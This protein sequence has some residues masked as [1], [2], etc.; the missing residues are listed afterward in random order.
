ME[1]IREAPRMGGFVPLTEFQSV[2]PETFSQPVLHY[3]SD[4][5]KVIVLE[6]ELQH[7]PAIAELITKASQPVH[8][9]EAESENTNG[10]QAAQKT[11]EDIDVWVTSEKLFL[12]SK[13][14]EIG[15]TISYPTIS[16][17]ATQSYPAPSPD[18]PASQALYMQLIPSLPDSPAEDDDPPDTVSLT[19]IPTAAAPP[20]STAPTAN[21]DDAITSENEPQLTPVQALYKALSDCSDLHP[22]PAQDEDMEE[23]G[24]SRL[25]PAGLAIPGTTD[26]SMPP[27]MPGSGGWITAEN[28]HEFVDEEGNWIGGD[29][30]EQEDAQ[31]LG[32][33]A[34]T[35]RSRPDGDAQDGQDEETKWQRTS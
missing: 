14:H 1:V 33:G 15:L 12:Y 23:S 31:N 11:V 13:S 35:V 18:E 19:I 29:D 30:E 17:H 34:G 6:D 9:N 28:M 5:C 4:R 7:A 16:I 26:G 8:S 2:T 3:Y 22:D 20:P 10:A 24:M 21:E 32:P 25:I 27:A